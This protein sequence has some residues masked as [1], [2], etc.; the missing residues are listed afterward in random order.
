VDYSAAAQASALAKDLSSLKPLPAAAAPAAVL[1]AWKNFL[2]QIAQAAK[3]PKV[4][5]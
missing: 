2:Q 3:L 1:G 5:L 4:T